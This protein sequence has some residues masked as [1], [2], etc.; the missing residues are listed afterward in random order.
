M[1]DAGA[2]ERRLTAI[3][4]TDVV[5]YSARMQ[6]DET[7]TMALVRIDFERMRALCAQHGGEVLKS[8]GDGLLLCFSSVVQ[9]VACSLQIQKE[10]GRDTRRPALSWRNRRRS[11]AEEPRFACNL[12]RYKPTWVHV[13][14]PRTHFLPP[15]LR[16][17]QTAPR[18]MCQEATSA[19]DQR[20][21]ADRCI[22][23]R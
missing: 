19:P 21:S 6:R 14:R 22:S 4:F 12:I 3:V 23:I 15:S 8:T 13:R 9:A 2:N 7:G 20:R 5:G 16:L 10:F 18:P 1:S 11:S 17:G